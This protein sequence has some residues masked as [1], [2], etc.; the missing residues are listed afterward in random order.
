M[1]DNFVIGDL[2]VLLYK[3][4]WCIEDGCIDQISIKLHILGFTL[5]MTSSSSSANMTIL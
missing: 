3:A 4:E 5:R 2:R 1:R